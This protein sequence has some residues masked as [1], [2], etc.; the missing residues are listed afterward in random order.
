MMAHMRNLLQFQTSDEPVVED[1]VC[2]GSSNVD[3]IITLPLAFIFL[4]LTAMIGISAFRN[5]KDNKKQNSALKY[6]LYTSAISAFI[7]MFLHIIIYTVCVAT[8]A[9]AGYKIRGEDSPIVWIPLM[10][11]SMLLMCILATLIVTFPVSLHYN[12]L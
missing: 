11:Y 9:A 10:F 1:G 7:E 2:Y 12:V 8:D 5:L 4:I 3:E 6:L